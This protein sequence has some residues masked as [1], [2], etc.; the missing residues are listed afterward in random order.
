VTIPGWFD[1]QVQISIYGFNPG[2]SFKFSAPEA[3]KI[4]LEKKKN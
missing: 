1:L 2:E 3:R 4:V